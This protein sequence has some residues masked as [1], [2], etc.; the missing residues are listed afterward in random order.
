[1]AQLDDTIATYLTAIE[2]EGKTQNTVLSYRASMEDFRRVPRRLGLPDGST[3][4]DRPDQAGSQVDLGERLENAAS[5]SPPPFMTKGP[6][7]ARAKP[8][9]EPLAPLIRQLGAE[10]P[11][12]RHATLAW[13]G[14]TRSAST[15][16]FRSTSA[17]RLHRQC[18]GGDNHLCAGDAE[19]PRDR[20]AN[21]SGRPRD[22]RY[23]PAQITHYSSPFGWNGFVRSGP[24]VS[25][26]MSNISSVVHDSPLA[27]ARASTT[28]SV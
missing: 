19:A 22:D 4:A 11:S 8:V 12:C 28:G 26:K 21:T 1:M 7:E 20:L 13:G 6:R 2:V 16:S 5:Q 24:R 27:N 18:P 25:G 23:L 14:T 10:V 9:R 15:T 17:T 3:E